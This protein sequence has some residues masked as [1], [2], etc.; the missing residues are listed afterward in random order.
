[1][2]ACLMWTMLGKGLH[3][4]LGR[5]NM[6]LFEWLPQVSTPTA[7]S[8]IVRSQSGNRQQVEQQTFAPQQVCAV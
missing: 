6:P 2:H 5:K 8:C 4:F 7:L 3:L 1:M